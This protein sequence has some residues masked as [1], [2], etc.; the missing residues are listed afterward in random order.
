MVQLHIDPLLMWGSLSSSLKFLPHLWEREYIQ[1]WRL[2]QARQKMKEEHGRGQLKDRQQ[3]ENLALIPV[4]KAPIVSSVPPASST[5]GVV[6]V[7]VVVDSFFS[8]QSS[9]FW[10]CMMGTCPTPDRIKSKACPMDALVLSGLK[11]MPACVCTC[12]WMHEWVC[13]CECVH[14]EDRDKQPT[15]MPT[16][17]R[18]V[19]R[20][21]SHQAGS[22]REHLGGSVKL[23]G[24][25]LLIWGTNQITW[26]ELTWL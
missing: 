15:N 22:D 4:K 24:T 1:W 3:T 26:P 8:L 21:R 17:N 14:V 7:V 23:S 12:A 19:E 18:A 13:V 5:L 10:A 11:S 16:N 9:C 20:S 6:V 25:K 2:S